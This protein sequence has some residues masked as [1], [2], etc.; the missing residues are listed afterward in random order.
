[1]TSAERRRA[2]LLAL[3][4]GALHIAGF[5]ILFLLVAPQ[6]LKLGGAAFSVGVGFTAYTLGMRHAFDADHIAAI[7]NTTRKL[8]SD[9]KRPL[10]VG[11]WFSLGHSTI[12][13]GLCLLLSFGVRAIVGQVTDD[14]STLHHWTGLVGTGVSGVFLLLL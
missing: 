6:H 13:F 11:L 9:G 14:A 5:G 3:A 7:D 8:M 4:I 2:G 12:V 10:S 1:M